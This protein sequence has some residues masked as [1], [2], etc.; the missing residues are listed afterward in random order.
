MFLCKPLIY[1]IFIGLEVI[2]IAFGSQTFVALF[3]TDIKSQ[4]AASADVWLEF[5]SEIPESKEFTVCHWIKIQFYN[6]DSVACLWSYCTADNPEQEMICSQVCMKAAYY[7]SNRNLIFGSGIKV[8][9]NDDADWI[10]V[11]L[12]HYRHRTWTHLCW[13]YSAHTGESKY[14]HDGII[15]GIEYLNVTYY[16]VALRASNGSSALLFGQEPDKMRGGFQ[17][18]QA[19]IG[20]LTEFNVWSSTLS[21]TDILNMGS[22]RAHTKG[23]V[24]KWDKSGILSRN[25]ALEDVPDISFLCNNDPKYLIFPRKMR[26]SEGQMTCEIHGGAIAVPKSDQ[27]SKKILDIVSKHQ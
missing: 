16:D 11:E 3:Q 2:N 26:F 23:N 27:E 15:F 19:F 21:D 17:K 20:Y 8:G 13:S 18:G 24:V 5:S 22:C 10:W 12:K 25:V 7:T 9:N 14:Y 4:K 6:S 1:S